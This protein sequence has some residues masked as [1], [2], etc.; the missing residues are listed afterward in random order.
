M[1]FA[2]FERDPEY[3]EEYQLLRKQLGK[4]GVPMTFVVR[5]STVYAALTETRQ[6]LTDDSPTMEVS[7]Q[8]TSEEGQLV[9]EPFWAFVFLGNRP[10]SPYWVI[11]RIESHPGGLIVRYS[12]PPRGSL[13]R[14]AYPHA[15]W[16]PLGDLPSGAFTLRLFDGDSNSESLSFRLRIVRSKP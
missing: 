2:P 14:I 16:I 13:S 1:K 9:T 5:A 7:D 8:G 6:V 12:Q 4:V 15:Y 11:E 3:K 10:P